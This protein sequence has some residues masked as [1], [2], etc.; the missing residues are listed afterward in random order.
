MTQFKATVMDEAALTRAVRRIS[1][2]IIERN[3][4]VDGLV[5]VGIRRRGLPLARMIQQNIAAIEGVTLPLEALNI[6][7]Y[8]DDL[9]EIANAPRVGNEPMKTDVADKK[10]ILVDDV[11]F[12]G[13]TARAAIDAVFAA[14]RPAQIQLAV[15]IDRG[16]RELPIRA[17]YVG[18]SLPTAHSER[19]AVYLPE[20]DGKTGAEIVELCSTAI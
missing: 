10:V 7:F 4:G 17:D 15:L 9:T 6:Q 18:K 16:H 14:G 11:L 3:K 8:R 12:T 2:E 19:V 13:R 5:L 1:H 20:Y